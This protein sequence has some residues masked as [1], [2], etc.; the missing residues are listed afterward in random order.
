VRPSLQRAAIERYRQDVLGPW[1][2]SELA[3]Q[4]RALG[5]NYWDVGGRQVPVVAGGTSFGGAETLASQEAS[6]GNIG[7]TATLLSLLT[8]VCIPAVGPQYYLPIGRRFAVKAT[9]NIN[10]TATVPTYQFQYL[11]SPTT[12]AFADPL[13]SS[14]MLAQNATI[15]PVAASN[16][17]W[18]LDLRMATRSSGTQPSTNGTILCIGTLM[19]NWAASATYVIT[20]FKNATPPTAVT[21]NLAAGLYF[22]LEVIMGAATAGNTA[23]CFDYELLSLN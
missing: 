5:W 7:P 10:T 3:R 12:N 1:L 14:V 15:T 18:Y 13:A 21:V 20:P 22:D 6:S 19:N 4:E 9:G 2:E 16:L 8:R 11:A 17:D 23:V